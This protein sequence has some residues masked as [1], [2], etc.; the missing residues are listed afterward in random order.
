MNTHTQLLQTINIAQLYG[1]SKTF[2]DKPTV[3]SSNQTLNDFYALYT[4]QSLPGNGTIFLERRWL[5]QRDG[6]GSGSGSGSGKFN[7]AA[8]RNG[9]RYAN[10]KRSATVGPPTNYSDVTYGALETFVEV[11]FVS[12]RGLVSLLG[13][14]WD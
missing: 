11:D 4:N 7:A 13:A 12:R 14:C 9:K 2:V 6:S 10:A 8:L 5:A 3:F 1:D